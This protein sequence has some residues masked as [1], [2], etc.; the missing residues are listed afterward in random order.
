MLLV[1]YTANLCACMIKSCDYVF[2]PFECCALTGIE[3]EDK[4]STD[5]LAL[6]DAV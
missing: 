2:H 6:F 1:A 5:K 4:N 3:V